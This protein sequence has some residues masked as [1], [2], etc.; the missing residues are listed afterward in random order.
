MR[1]LAGLRGHTVSRSALI[2]QHMLIYAT[3]PKQKTVQRYTASKSWILL[4][5]S[6]QSLPSRPGG[7]CAPLTRCTQVLQNT[8]DWQKAMRARVDHAVCAENKT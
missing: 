2:I 1:K 3:K 8:C 4:Q 5:G 6:A 7:G